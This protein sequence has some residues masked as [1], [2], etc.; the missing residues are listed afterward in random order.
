M[1]VG[2]A[3]Q[4]LSRWCSVLL[5]THK[6][7]VRHARPYDEPAR[8]THGDASEII[9]A[10]PSRRERTH[11]AEAERTKTPELQ[12]L[13][14]DAVGLRRAEPALGEA[15]D[16]RGRPLTRTARDA[17]DSRRRCGARRATWWRRRSDASRLPPPRE[18]KRSSA[19]PRIALRDLEKVSVGSRG[20]A[21]DIAGDRRLA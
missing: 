18:R 12:R 9:S 13:H 21:N 16:K 6:R 2:A 7:R 4:A 3:P 11:G 17:H 8:D 10:R 1:A 15:H 20:R 14:R 5:A 19:R